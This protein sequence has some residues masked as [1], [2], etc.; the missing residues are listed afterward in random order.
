[1]FRKLIHSF[2]V[3]AIFVTNSAYAD[4]WL[5]YSYPKKREN[6]AVQRGK[7]SKI[8]QFVHIKKAARDRSSLVDFDA[9]DATKHIFIPVCMTVFQLY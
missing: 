7:N 8:A 3:H 1:M 2:A 5:M 9:D 6:N 4:S